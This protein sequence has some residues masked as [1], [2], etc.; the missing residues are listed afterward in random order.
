MS[1]NYPVTLKKEIEPLLIMRVKLS[2]LWELNY[3]LSEVGDAR[4]F[5]IIFAQDMKDIEM[6]K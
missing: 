5:Y 4:L 2:Q 1:T 3:H 6:L